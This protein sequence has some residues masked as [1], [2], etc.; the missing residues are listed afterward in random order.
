MPLTMSV[1]KHVF[2]QYQISEYFDFSETNLWRHIC[3]GSILLVHNIMNMVK[4]VH[5]CTFSSNIPAGEYEGCISDQ[6]PF[7][8]LI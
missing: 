7:M 4:Q 2:I 3:I 8:L 1:L 5:G 6:V